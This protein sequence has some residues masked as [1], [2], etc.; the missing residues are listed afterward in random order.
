MDGFT[1]WPLNTHDVD[2]DT[3]YSYPH[4]PLYRPWIRVNFVSSVDGAA[5]INGLTAGLGSPPDKRVF[6]KLRELA[7]V[8]LVGAG[9]ARAERYGGVILSTDAQNRR[10]KRGQ[11]PIPP[12]AVVSSSARLDPA[13]PLFVDTVVPP[14]ILTTS[15]APLDCRERLIS[16][17]ADLAIVGSSAAEVGQIL[18]QLQ[19][20]K[21]LRVLCEGGP[22][23]FGT[24]IAAEAVDELCLTIAPCLAGPGAGRI[25]AGHVL[26][27]PAALQLRAVLA[28]NDV[29]MLQYR[30][31]YDIGRC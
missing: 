27:E 21:L 1:S 30:T 2:L 22:R 20:R 17:G 16:A 15:S 10:A 31:I 19:S 8:V 14:L 11:A 5:E 3:F 7:D 25:V 26:P 4:P 6:D 23:L 12:V 29:L 18:H 28:E 9:T 13:G 24:M